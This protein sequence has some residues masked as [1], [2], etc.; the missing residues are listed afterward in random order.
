VIY[1]GY[2][3]ALAFGVNVGPGI[4]SGYAEDGMSIVTNFTIFDGIGISECS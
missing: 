2:I 1:K 3:S 4:E